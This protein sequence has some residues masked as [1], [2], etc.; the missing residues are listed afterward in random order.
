MRYFQKSIH[1]PGYSQ[2]VAVTEQPVK[3]LD[4]SIHPPSGVT[5]HPN[6]LRL[7]EFP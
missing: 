5:E 7:V 3:D 4:R 1:K 6:A 2:S